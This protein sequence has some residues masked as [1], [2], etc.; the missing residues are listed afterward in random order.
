MA[1]LPNRVVQFPRSDADTHP[2]ARYCQRC[3]MALGGGVVRPT[4]DLVAAS[5]ESRLIAKMIDLP[6]TMVSLIVAR[7]LQSRWPATEQLQLALILLGVFGMMAQAALLS[8]DGQTIGKRL[9][10]STGCYL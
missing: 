1:N 7:V 4:R 8:R 10:V 5:R 3:D 2:D 9:R 6:F